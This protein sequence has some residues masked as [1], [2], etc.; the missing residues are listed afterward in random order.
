MS[1]TEADPVVPAETKKNVKANVKIIVQQPKVEKPLKEKK[2]LSDAQK[3]TLQ[4]MNQARI[5]KKKAIAD[6]QKQRED[7]ERK[8]REEAVRKAEE[9]AK[10]I[11]DTVI[12]QKVR[13]RK[14][15]GKNAEKPKIERVQHEVLTH[16]EPPRQLT[17]REYT[18]MA[19]RQR[20]MTIN[21]DATPY[22]LKMVQSR[23]R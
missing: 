20:G 13:G 6:E 12:V 9:E 14:T 22:Y 18:I 23:M 2:P 3:A 15:G 16:N 10:K 8:G 11:S 5:A 21:D 17:H 1:D 7:E 4:K 19:L